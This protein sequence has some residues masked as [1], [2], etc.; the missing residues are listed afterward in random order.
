MEWIIDRFDNCKHCEWYVIQKQNSGLKNYIS[1][2]TFYIYNNITI[3][4]ET[5]RI[6]QIL[7]NRLHKNIVYKL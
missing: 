6:K 3:G 2:N 4:N 5:L 1:V 7:E